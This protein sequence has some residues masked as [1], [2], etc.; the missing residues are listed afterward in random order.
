MR[1]FKK[2]TGDPVSSA[3]NQNAGRRSS[4]SVPR[5]GAGASGTGRAR[6][7]QERIP[8]MGQNRTFSYHAARSQS[9]VTTGR[10]ATQNKPAIRRLPT[11][12]QRLRKHAGWLVLIVIFL[13]VVVYELELST[14]P[15]VVSLAESSDQP[16]LRETAVYQDAAQKLFAASA[17][18]RNKLTVDSSQIALLMRVQFPEL[19]EVSV[20]L[21]II[22][23]RPTVYVRPADPAL[24]LAATNGTFVVD[25]NGRALAT[26]TGGSAGLASLAKIGV[27][28][29]TDQS[30][31]SAKLG[32]QVLPKDVASFIDAIAAQLKAKKIELQSMTLPTAAGELDVYV[33]GQTYF[34]KY[35]LQEGGAEAANAQ[36]GSFLAVK[37]QLEQQGKKP[38]QYIDV[39]L[40]GRTYWK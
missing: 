2:N 13:G 28:T 37:R 14:M 40:S 21:P 26:L 9:E 39:R 15:R 1:L 6:N 32:Q 35:N 17:T 34:V 27:P 5:S 19:A 11:R 29:V 24:V 16:F 20:A 12:L 25:E 7:Q 22:G 10:E 3:T 31:L 38:S 30:S 33:A 4:R 8:Q 36:T 23:D 18:N